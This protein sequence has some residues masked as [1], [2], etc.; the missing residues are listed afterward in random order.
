MN[1]LFDSLRRQKALEIGQTVYE[2]AGDNLEMK[3]HINKLILAN[4]DKGEDKITKFKANI[5]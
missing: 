4:L 5:Q 2:A 3:K 1:R